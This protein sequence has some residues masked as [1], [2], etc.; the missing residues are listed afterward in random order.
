MKEVKIIFEYGFSECWP[1][2]KDDKILFFKST[3]LEHRET[4]L[5]LTVGGKNE[6]QQK[7][8]NKEKL[9]IFPT[10]GRQFFSF[11]VSKPKF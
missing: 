10:R 9:V 3:L 8:G 7:K 6:Q 5:T 1:C 2:S 11:C 4:Y